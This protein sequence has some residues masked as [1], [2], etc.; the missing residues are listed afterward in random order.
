VSCPN[1]NG[2]KLEVGSTK[3]NNQSR[4]TAGVTGLI[5]AIKVG[6]NF[7]VSTRTLRSRT[8]TRL[9]DLRRADLFR[10]SGTGQWVVLVF[11]CQSFGFK[12]VS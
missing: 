8:R 9:V 12:L 11:K 4:E 10:D 5:I 3:A 6:L 1:I 2:G 7:G